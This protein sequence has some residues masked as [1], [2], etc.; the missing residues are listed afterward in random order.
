[1]TQKSAG[2]KLYQNVI[3]APVIKGEVTLIRRV[4]WGCR[5]WMNIQ[6]KM[7]MEMFCGGFF[8]L[9]KYTYFNSGVL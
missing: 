1:M 3:T 5:N 8:S 9:L 7:E 6:M 4:S 2:K